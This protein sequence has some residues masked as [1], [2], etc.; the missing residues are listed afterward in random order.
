MASWLVYSVPT[1]WRTWVYLFDAS[2]NKT[3]PPP[4]R[5]SELCL[6]MYLV[7]LGVYH[8]VAFMVEGHVSNK[9]SRNLDCA[10]SFPQNRKKNKHSRTYNTFQKQIILEYIQIL[11][12]WPTASAQSVRTYISVCWRTREPP[13]PSKDCAIINQKVC[14]FFH[15]MYPTIPCVNWDGE[16][17]IACSVSSYYQYSLTNYQ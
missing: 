4:L 17:L 9:P 7:G 3:M 8:F 12:F 5:S 6:V 11:L 16:K 2:K 15:A 13:F 14:V 1:G 10:S